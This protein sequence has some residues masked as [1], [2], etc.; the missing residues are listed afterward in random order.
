MSW[1]RRAMFQRKKTDQGI[2]WT[3]T[4]FASHPCLELESGRRVC[5]EKRYLYIVPLELKRAKLP[6]CKV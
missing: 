3:M 5:V 1:G 4:G 6:L 2:T